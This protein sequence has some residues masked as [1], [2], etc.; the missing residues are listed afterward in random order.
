MI[1]L[2]ME[3][4]LQLGNILEKLAESL[5]LTESQYKL[6]TERY[7]AVGEWLS[8]DDSELS[9]FNPKIKPQGSIRTGTPVRPINE[10]DEFDVDTTCYLEQSLPSCQKTLKSM[11]GKRL[12][13][14][15]TYK[16][17]SEEKR[18]CWRLRYAESSRF[19]LILFPQFQIIMDG[20]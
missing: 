8:S 3:E 16:K 2:T 10:N 4:K 13:D 20:Y 5:D 17:M 18:R 7:K 14:N 12:K 6:A 11:V 9:V 1:N 19:T 15:D